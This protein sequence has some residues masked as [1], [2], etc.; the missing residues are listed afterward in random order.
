MTD[1]IARLRADRAEARRLDDP[2]A[3]LC[4]LATVADGEPQ[5]RTLVL[6]DGPVSGQFAIFLNGN[7]PK[8]RQLAQ[9]AK[10]QAVVYLPS[11][12]VQYRLTC[13]LQALSEAF[14]HNS[15]QL[16]PAM[17]KRLDWLYER[18]P[19]GAAVKSRQALLA[20]LDG[21]VPNAAPASALG[22]QLL[23]KVVERLALNQPNGVHDRRRYTLCDEIWHEE[24]LVP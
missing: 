11:L 20:M 2:N 13:T 17:P 7:S 15:W 12:A 6:R 23:P 3:N 8:H 4:V 9:S 1:P 10:V 24:V 22:Y 5:A 14:V 16:R 21:P 18:H 19:Q